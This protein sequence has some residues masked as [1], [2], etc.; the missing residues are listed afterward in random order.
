[1]NKPQIRFDGFTDAWEQRRLGN[2][3]ETIATGKSKFVSGTDKSVDR[4]YAVLGSTSVIGYDSEYDHTGDFI[5]TARV[6]AN[7][8]NLYKHSGSVKISDNTVFIQSKNLDYIFYLLVK[9]NIKKLSFGTGQPLVK[10]SEL[11]NLD[12]L[13]PVHEIE[14]TKIGD[15]FR[16]LDRLLTLHQREYSKTL[17]IKKALLEKMFPKNGADVPE[18]RFAGFTD[19]W[20]QRILGD[21]GSTFTGLSGKTKEDFG[22]GEAEFVT[23][24]NVFANPIAAANFT[25]RVE[26]DGTQNEVK[27]G[28]V[29]FTT[30]S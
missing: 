21:I 7:A 2:F 16:N 17:N 8:G 20:E 10:A 30:S 6:G 28:D 13:F 25:E 29:F 12:L 14:Q 23:Y 11:N 3:V 19:A 15:L 5:L 18:I 27:Y 26:I 22:H 4:P 9:Y 24:M 1:M